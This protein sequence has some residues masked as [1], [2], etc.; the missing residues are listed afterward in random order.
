MEASGKA[1]PVLKT[2]ISQVT[3]ADALALFRTWVA[4]R[5]R[6]RTVVAA[7]VHLVT[8]AALDPGYAVV[9]AD[10]ELVVPDGMPLVWASRLLGGQLTERC[11]GP[12]LM[13]K[14]LDAFQAQNATHYFYGSTPSVLEKL[15]L[16]VGTRWPRACVVGA[17]SPAFGPFNDAEEWANIRAINEAGAQFLWLGMGC[18]KQER[19][20]HRYRT[21]L[22]ASVVLAV[23]A[24][25]DFLAGTVPQAPPAMQRLGLEWLYRL[26]ME[27]RRLWRRYVFRN[28]Y[29]LAC[30]AVQYVRHLLS[31][32]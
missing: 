12:T 30:L 29:F 26:A 32:R 14:T 16:A 27:P 5:D 19:W 8:E 4:D 18:P 9:I 7:N 20:M 21:R 28:P 13:E 24:A 15:Q 31:R 17:S 10:A 25:F 23:G 1:I 11:Y 2:R 22:D 6:V 3:Y